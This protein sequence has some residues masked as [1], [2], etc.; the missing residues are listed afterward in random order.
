MDIMETFRP[1]IYETLCDGDTNLQSTKKR[2]LKAAEIT[3][4]MFEK[5]MLRHKNSLV[6]IT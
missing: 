6:S 1:D 4:T 5:C 3:S 2:C